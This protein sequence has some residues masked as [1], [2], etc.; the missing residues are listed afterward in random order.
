MKQEFG[1]IGAFDPDVDVA[2][3]DAVQDRGLR[4]FAG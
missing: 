4:E 1:A 2:G 3:A